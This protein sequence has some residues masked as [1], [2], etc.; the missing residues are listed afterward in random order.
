[1][2]LFAMILTVLVLAA[3]IVS[4]DDVLTLTNTTG[5]LTADATMGS[6]YFRDSESTNG[7]KRYV[8]VF[9]VDPDPN[10]QLKSSILY[11]SEP[12]FTDETDME[13]RHSLKLNDLLDKHNTKR[14]KFQNIPASMKFGRDIMLEPIKLR[15]LRIVVAVVAKF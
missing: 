8:Q 15:D 2:K 14:V 3:G 10:V 9:V 13:I 1:M 12:F 7:V 11:K 5:Y 6:F 4:A